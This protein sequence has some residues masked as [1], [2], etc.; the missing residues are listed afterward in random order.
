VDRKRAEDALSTL[1]LV[2]GVASIGYLIWVMFPGLRLGLSSR[3]A[4]AVREYRAWWRERHAPEQMD[5]E[6]SIVLAA[7]ARG[8]DLDRSLPQ[9]SR[10]ETLGA[11]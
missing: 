1:Q 10:Q 11:G 7:M 3:L 6:M 5:Y 9:S 2:V 8:G 4:G